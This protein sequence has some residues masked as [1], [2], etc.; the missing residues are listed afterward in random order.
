MF[1]RMTSHNSTSPKGGVLCSKD[2]CVG[3][4]TS[5]FKIKFSGKSNAIWVAAKHFSQL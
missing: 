5:V 1:E 2:S 3:N 4:R